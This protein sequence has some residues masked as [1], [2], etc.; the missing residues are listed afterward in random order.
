MLEYKKYRMAIKMIAPHL[1]VIEEDAA[2]VYYDCKSKAIVIGKYFDPNDYGFMRHLDQKHGFKEGIQIP[3]AVWHFLHEIGHFEMEEK[4]GDNLETREWFKE[5]GR[6]MIRNISY[7]NMFWDTRV[8]WEATEWAIRWV[9]DH[10]KKVK[11]LSLL[12][13][14]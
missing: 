9:K 5:N 1:P 3:Y 11:A 12:L 14:E 6:F 8:E 4:Y 13:R 7:Q 10:P 2:S